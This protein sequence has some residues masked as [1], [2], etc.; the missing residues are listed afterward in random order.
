MSEKTKGYI[1]VLLSAVCFSI[2]GLLIKLNSWS[3]VSINGARC[4]FAFFV[5]LL[6]LKAIN[7]K[8]VINKTVLLGAV[9]NT[10]MSTTFVVAN[11]LT[12]AANAIILQFTMPIYIVLML[13]IFWKKKPNKET[14]ITCLTAFIGFIFFFFDSIETGGM[15]GNILALISGVLYAGVFLIKKMDGS[16]F[17]SSALLSFLLSFVV[18]LPFIAQETD[19]STVNIITIIVLG[20]V[21]IGFSYIFLGLGLNQVSP[22][23][24]ALLSMLEP[25]LSPAIVAVFYGEM[26]GGFG[27][28]GAA[29]VIASGTV[30]NVAQAKSSATS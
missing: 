30:Y 23:G 3:G 17:E 8:I 11:K 18:A 9:I 24:A 25:V 2:G 7:H 1:Y 14:V 26:I 15:A 20:V 10:G 29:I 12:A 27:L 22:V 6:Y 5:M 28:I 19:Y 21:Q 16:D 4:I 13:W